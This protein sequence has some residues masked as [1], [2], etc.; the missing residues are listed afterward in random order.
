MIS[1]AM[2]RHSIIWYGKIWYG[3]VWKG[4][5]R[6]VVILLGM[7]RELYGTGRHF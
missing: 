4:L 1:Y 7:V 3:M 2:E 6:Y 5:V